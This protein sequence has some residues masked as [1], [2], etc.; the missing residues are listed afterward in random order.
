MRAVEALCP[1]DGRLVFVCSVVAGCKNRC[2]MCCEK[3]DLF[4]FSSFGNVEGI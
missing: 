1:R 4:H 2:S 3:C